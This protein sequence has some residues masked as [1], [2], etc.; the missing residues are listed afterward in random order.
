[1]LTTNGLKKI[2]DSRVK[3][4]YDAICHYCI[5]HGFF[6]KYL[7]IYDKIPSIFPSIHFKYLLISL[8]YYTSNLFPL[9][10]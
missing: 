1:M 2:K 9:N 6:S 7:D 4:N 5:E 10:F 8:F 3:I